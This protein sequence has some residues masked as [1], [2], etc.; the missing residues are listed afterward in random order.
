MSRFLLLRRSF[1]RCSPTVWAALAL[2][3]PTLLTGCPTTSPGDRSDPAAK[4]KQADAKP[5]PKKP[6]TPSIK[7]QSG[8]TAFLS[9]MGRLRKAAAAHDAEFL[10]TLMTPDFGYLLEPTAEDTGSGRGA[11][12]YWERNNL[13]P[14]LELVLR[15]R[16][17]PYGNFMVSPPEFAVE[18]GNYKGYRAGIQLVNGGWKF[19]YFVKG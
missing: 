9:F 7:D 16:F 8:D 10:A 12:T 6:P 11:F 13:W 1:A 4:T 17:V 19:A 15:E 18:E 5:K 14:E 2:L 3:S